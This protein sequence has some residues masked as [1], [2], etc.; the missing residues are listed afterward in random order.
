LIFKPSRSW[1]QGYQILEIEFL[2]A[3]RPSLSAIVLTTADRLRSSVSGPAPSI[4]EGGAKILIALTSPA[5]KA[6]PE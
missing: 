5:L 4:L 1:L 3:V 2:R 6:C